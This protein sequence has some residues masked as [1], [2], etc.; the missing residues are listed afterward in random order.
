[1]RKIKIILITGIVVTI[2]WC[3]T[4]GFYITTQIGWDALAF[5][6]PHE[7]GAFSAGV[8]APLAFLWLM[9]VYLAG[10]ARVTDVAV[11]LEKR[12]DQLIYPADEADQRIKEVV[13]TLERHG[14][15]L[16][17]SGALMAET[18]E[19]RM[20]KAVAD[21]ES[22]LEGAGLSFDAAANETVDRIGDA[23]VRLDGKR[24]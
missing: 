8:F 10:R 1:M 6:L 19:A 4:V 9:L 14:T 23:T 2:A 5:L 22:L 18:V 16:A 20:R 21:M 13:D 11:A 24:E 7:L 3:G 15:D 17:A 12:L